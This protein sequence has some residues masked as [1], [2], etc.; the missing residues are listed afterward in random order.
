MSFKNARNAALDNQVYPSR[1]LLHQS[2]LVRLLL[3]SRLPVKKA[4]R[5]PALSLVNML[6]S[7]F[8]LL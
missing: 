1:D 7:K 6:Q 2:R 8:I 3:G 4:G 5:G